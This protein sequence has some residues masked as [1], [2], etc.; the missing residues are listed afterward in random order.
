MKKEHRGTLL[1]SLTVITIFT[2]TVWYIHY[3]RYF[4]GLIL[5]DAMDYAGIARNVARGQ[6][7][8]S[9][10]VTPLSLAHYG[11]PQPDMWRAPLWPLAL[12]GFQKIFGFI[13][14]ASAIGTG[15]F[16]IATAPVIFLLARQWFGNLVAF[17][18]VLIY[19]FTPK[20]LYFS[21]SG[22]TEPMAIFLMTLTLLMVSNKN[23]KNGGGDW[24]SGILLGLFYLTR[25]NALVFLPFFL[26]YRYYFRLDGYLSPARM[27]A[28][29]TLTILPWLVRNT[30][31]FGN[32][33]FSL[34]KYE[35]AMFTPTY[36][37]YSLYLYSIKIN[38]VE[39]ILS[40]PADIAAKITDSWNSYVSS[41][42]S[43]DL[44][45]VSAAIFIIFLASLLIPMEKATAGI[46]PLV[47][48]CYLVQLTALVV[49]HFI[50]RLFL[51]FAPIYIIFA[52]GALFTVL[53]IL[54][55]RKLHKS[56]PALLTVI[57]ILILSFHNY[58]SPG[59][60]KPE[61]PDRD[62]YLEAINQLTYMVP[63][64][65]AI[66]TN[67]GHLISWYGDRYASKIP[68]SVEM[69]PDIKKRADFGALFISDRILWHMP[70]ADQS[71]KFLWYQ[72]P[73]ELYNLKLTEVINDSGLIYMSDK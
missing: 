25:Y 49:I 67:E 28:G 31:I 23:F 63:T 7:F 50:P 59:L 17:G 48:S 40:H 55:K 47:V 12:A 1:L 18:S 72:Q 53:N 66:L 35:P 2:A 68:Y 9:Q 69:I 65:K 24:L 73:R 8:I 27:L 36:P 71:W 22:M 38:M 45:G 33:M 61:V 19:V 5:N 10:Y 20:L 44:N 6:G 11:I 57:A 34:Q 70:E 62:R 54:L 43:P 21:I 14:E 26:L 56:I 41:F 42:L 51:I 13:D 60:Q 29:F 39:F 30:I 3:D 37:D 64:D 46:R 16:F 58:T 4:T 52:L 15:F 32:P